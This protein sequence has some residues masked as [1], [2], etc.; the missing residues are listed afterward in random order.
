MAT[1]P[2]YPSSGP[3]AVVGYML[4]RATELA[5]E[6]Y[7]TAIAAIEEVTESTRTVVPLEKDNPKLE[8][9]SVFPQY[10][11]NLNALGFDRVFATNTALRTKL[12]GAIEEQT[13]KYFTDIFP[14]DSGIS[15]AQAWLAKVYAGDALDPVHEERIWGREKDRIRKES[16]KLTNETLSLWAGKGYALPPGAAVGAVAAIQRTQLEQAAAVSRDIAIKTYEKEIELL[17]D[18]VDQTIRMRVESIKN[19][20]DYIK[21]A[22][23]EPMLITQVEQST[24]DVYAKL[25][26]SA[27]EYF[28][29]ED[30]YRSVKFNKDKEFVG[31]NRDF[32]KMS[33]DSEIER[34]KLQTA[35]VLEAAKLAATMAA[36]SLNGI[37]AQA[38][39]GGTDS[40]ST[41]TQLYG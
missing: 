21:L 39:I 37:H 23:M 17:K 31:F 32:N 26:Q 13:E 9:M 36:A 14:L 12:E 3:A 22:V 10:P 19:M 8:A 1:A 6:L 40:T 18:A 16:E 25:T 34:A 20:A 41:N 4:D 38:S 5:D 24:T 15:D 11:D 35:N 29:V 28:R 2:S 30:S 7:D 33:F 27:Y